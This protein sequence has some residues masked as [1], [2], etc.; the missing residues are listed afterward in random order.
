MN[1]FEK[2]LENVDVS[3]FQEEDVVLVSDYPISDFCGIY[4]LLPIALFLLTLV[5]AFV[6]PSSV[7]TINQSEKVL[8]GDGIDG[9][10]FSS[11]ISNLTPFS[12]FLRVFFRFDSVTD[13]K[14]VFINGTT[15]IVSICNEQVQ[16]KRMLQMPKLK[17]PVSRYN[18]STNLI[19][20]Y[21]SN[22]ITFDSINISIL[23]NSIPANNS[24]ITIIWETCDPTVVFIDAGIRLALI[25]YFLI[26]FISNGLLMIKGAKML[27]SQRLTYGLFLFGILYIDPFSIINLILPSEFNLKY[28]LICKNCFYSFFTFFVFTTLSTISTKTFQSSKRYY[29][30]IIIS[31][32]LFI[33]FVFGE[34]NNEIIIEGLFSSQEI[35]QKSPQLL[36]LIMYTVVLI[37][38]LIFIFL[39]YKDSQS[40]ESSSSNNEVKIDRLIYSFWSTVPLYIAYGYYYYLRDYKRSIQNTFFEII[41]PKILVA[42]FLFITDH[43]Q[44]V[45]TEKEQYLNQ[46]SYNLPD[47]D[48]IDNP[49]GIDEDPDQM[50]AMIIDE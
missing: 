4:A 29:F 16:T 25:S 3:N 8:G 39:G 23:F 9:I 6:Y 24:L 28:S 5:L 26:Q 34:M 21:R 50:K 42:M 40:L 1:D 46:F 45:V 27:V 38:I 30:G 37:T 13:L 31:V 49:I 10:G 12:R 47:G 36:K 35:H 33:F 20:I 18:W 11:H 15:S 32:L 48:S 43:G 44:F 22:L 17:L 19:E 41:I 2:P 7:Q 14:E